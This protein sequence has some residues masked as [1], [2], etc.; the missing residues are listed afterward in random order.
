MTEQEKVVTDMDDFDLFNNSKEWNNFYKRKKKSSAVEWYLSWDELSPDIMPNLE[1]LQ[2]PN[3]LVPA[4]GDS[5]VSEQ[6]YSSGFLNITNVDYSSELIETMKNQHREKVGMQWLT[7]DVLAPLQES[8][9]L[10]PRSYDV[11]LDKGC[12]D[13]LCLWADL[14]SKGDKCLD[15]YLHNVKDLLGFRGKFII[16]TRLY[17]EN[18]LAFLYHRFWLGWKLTLQRVFPQKDSDEMAVMFVIEKCTNGLIYNIIQDDKNHKTL[19]AEVDQEN[20]SIDN[21]RKRAKSKEDFERSLRGKGVENCC[22]VDDGD[23]RIIVLIDSNKFHDVKKV[24]VLW[25]PEDDLVLHSNA[26]TNSKYWQLEHFFSTVTRASA[27]LF[28]DL[29]PLLETI[30]PKIQ[31]GWLKMW[32]EEHQKKTDGYWFPTYPSKFKAYPSKF[33]GFQEGFQKKWHIQGKRKARKG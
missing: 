2:S 16:L 22:E 27:L 6:L 18:T 8:P 32:N 4:C 1:N 15:Q 28:I 3:I 19:S 29:K 30:D 26:L 31:V 25:V 10:I 7:K 13:F 11:I 23:Y 5:R 17:W 24:D 21:Y 33:K 9:I 20:K 12:F 14:M